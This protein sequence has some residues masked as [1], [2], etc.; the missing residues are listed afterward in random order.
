MYQNI[1][2][3]NCRTVNEFMEAA[4]EYISEPDYQK[5]I[6]KLEAKLGEL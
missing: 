3:F 1:S 5:Y 4:K 6:A 2:E